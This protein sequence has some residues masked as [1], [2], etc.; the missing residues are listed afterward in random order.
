MSSCSPA[1]PTR[2]LD[3]LEESL[4]IYLCSCSPLVGGF[5]LCVSS[6]VTN[7]SSARTDGASVEELTCCKNQRRGSCHLIGVNGGDIPCFDQCTVGNINAPTA[8]V[9][10]AFC[11]MTGYDSLG[12]VMVPEAKHTSWKNFILPCPRVPVMVQA[13]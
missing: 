8:P 6:V 2:E 9:E 5:L 3:N 7:T 12:S 10:H 1:V 4:L 11:G 13:L